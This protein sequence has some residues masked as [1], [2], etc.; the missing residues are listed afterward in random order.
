MNAGIPGTEL[1]RSYRPAAEAIAPVR[2]ALDL[3]EISARAAHH[4]IRVAWTLADL[5]GEARPGPQ[6][7]GQALAFQL[8]VTR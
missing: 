8:G 1:R 2:R 4:V 5:A 6:E 7:C 3:G